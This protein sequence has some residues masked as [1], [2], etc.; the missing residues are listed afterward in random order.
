MS[1]IARDQLV[2][3]CVPLK[4]KKERK[5][6]VNIS[7]APLLSTP[8]ILDGSSPPFGTGKIIHRRKK[9]LKSLKQFWSFCEFSHTKILPKHL[10]GNRRNSV[11]FKIVGISI[12]RFLK[13]TTYL[14]R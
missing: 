8:P 2:C 12:T 5:K 6:E 10:L 9:K 14:T 4:E 1:G 11:P 13:S 3:L 7:S